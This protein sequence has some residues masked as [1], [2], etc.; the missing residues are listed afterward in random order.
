MARPKKSETTAKSTTTK[1]T[2][3]KATEET[4]DKTEE[5]VKEVMEGSTEEKPKPVGTLYN[6]INYNSTADLDNFIRNLTADQALYVVVQASRAAHTRNAYGIE[7]SELLSKAIRVL[8]TPP[9]Q[10]ETQIPEP[11]VHKA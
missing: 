3:S 8:T 9:K 1:K 11:E 7:E 4:V 2:T 10:E 5:Q 6:I